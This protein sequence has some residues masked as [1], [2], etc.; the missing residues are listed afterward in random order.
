MP[1]KENIIIDQPIARNPK[2]RLKMAIVQN[3]K[4][5]KTAFVKLKDNN[6][7]ELIGA[8]LFTGR[9]HQIRVHLN[10]INRHI[11]GDT[12]YGFKG[13]LDTFNQIFLHAYY[14]YLIHPTSKEL[15]YF[16]ADL[17]NNMKEFLNKNLKGYENEIKT[18]NIL[19]LFNS[20]F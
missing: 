3:G 20:S 5:A 7:I 8:K 11:L 18:D 1:L 9:T 14:L 19:N 4:N 12:L 15:L 17:P 13:N 2:N 6:D 16:K 10:Y